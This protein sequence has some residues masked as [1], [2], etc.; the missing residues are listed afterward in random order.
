MGAIQLYGAF[1]HNIKKI[2]G[3]AHKKR[4][5]DSKEKIE[6]MILVK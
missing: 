3:A 1:S 6:K 4:N 5:I 2:K